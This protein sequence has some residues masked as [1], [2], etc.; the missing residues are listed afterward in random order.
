MSKLQLSDIR[1]DYKKAS[2]N[3]KDVAKDPFEQ[4]DKWFEEVL[5]SK[6]EE[7]TA[8]TLASV[9]G[10][11]LPSARIV[12][13]KKVSDGGFYF[14]TNYESRKGRELADN[15]HAALVFFWKELERQVRIQGTVSKA[16]PEMSDS[17]FHSRPEGSQIGAWASPQ[18][19][20]V[21]SRDVLEKKVQE[22]K[23]RFNREPLYRPPFWGGFRLEPRLIEFWQ[24]RPSRLHDRIVYTKSDS[25][26]WKM[27]RLAP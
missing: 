13:L 7:P 4:F 5:H 12:L 1:T 6:V 16:S 25:Q 19:N 23:A 26:G 9:A 14:F 10:N 3:E 17:Y 2:L 21:A 24:G 15:P 22:M 18:S 8:M 20:V 11:G 27:E